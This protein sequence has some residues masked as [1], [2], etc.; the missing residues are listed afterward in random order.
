MLSY[1]HLHCFFTWTKGGQRGFS[2]RYLSCLI[3]FIFLYILNGYLGQTFCI[4]QWPIA[5]FG[6][7]KFV[8]FRTAFQVFS[9]GYLYFVNW[10]SAKTLERISFKNN[11]LKFVI[12]TPHSF[13]FLVLAYLQVYRPESFRTVVNIWS[14]VTYFKV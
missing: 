11:L 1:A 4:L 10:E 5:R 14:I 2:A 9:S 7:L 8:Y 12:H 3:K 6:K 13:R